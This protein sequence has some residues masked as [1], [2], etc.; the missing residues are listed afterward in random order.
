MC[1]STQS[2]HCRMP[3]LALINEGGGYLSPEV[4]N[5]SDFVVLHVFH[6]A[7]GDDA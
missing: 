1:K 4:E 5:L 3:D 2:V 7:R 6:L